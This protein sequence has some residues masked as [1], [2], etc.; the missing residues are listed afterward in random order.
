MRNDRIATLLIAAAVKWKEGGL[1]SSDTAA[2]PAQ[3][4]GANASG[5]IHT[6]LFLHFRSFKPESEIRTGCY[7]YAIRR[8]SD[9]YLKGLWGPSL[10]G[11]NTTLYITVTHGMLNTPRFSQ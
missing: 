9:V 4:K 5:A 1:N 11:L 3:R 7:S 8:G 2:K 6:Y 10:L